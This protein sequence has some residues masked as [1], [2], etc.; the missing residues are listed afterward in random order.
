M[1]SPLQIDGYTID[2][3]IG[4]GA[5]ATVYLAEQT[6]L[7]RQVA[8][9]V[10]SPSLANNETFAKRFIQEGKTIARLEQNNIVNIFDIGTSESC[11]YIA[12]E[13]L[14]GGT[15]KDR[16]QHEMYLNEALRIIRQIAQ[17]LSYAHQHHFVHRDIKPLN[18]MYRADGTVVLTDFGIAKE[19]AAA[20]T[21]LTATGAAIGTPTYM[22]PEQAKGEELDGRSDLYCLGVVFYELL[23]GV[24][25]YMASDPFALALQHINAPIPK[26]PERLSF[27]QGMLNKMMAKSPARRY[28]SAEELIAAIDHT[29]G[30]YDTDK[31]RV[32][33]NEAGSE[34]QTRVWYKTLLTDWRARLARQRLPRLLRILARRKRAAMFASATTLVAM[35]AAMLIYLNHLD[36][37]E[38][39]Q[40]QTLQR[41][42]Q[43]GQRQLSRAQVFFPQG[44]N[45]FDTYLQIRQLDPDN[46]E[47]RE[48]IATLLD[49]IHTLA[50]RTYENADWNRTL[51]LID[52]G[53]RL[54]SEH[55][56][57][58]SLQRNAREAQEQ[59]HQQKL[60]RE[61]EATIVSQL[62]RA[63]QQLQ[64]G[65]L[66]QP[67]DDNA[68]A[69]LRGI[70]RLSPEDPR[71][72]A[73]LR[74]VADAY[75]AQARQALEQGQWEQAE[76]LMEQGLSVVDSFPELIELG[77]QLADQRQQQ[78]IETL[79]EEADSLVA[80][81]QWV[82][83][84]DANALQRYRAVLALDADNADAQRGLSG[85]R[86]QLA[87]AA[88]SARNGGEFTTALNLV[89]QGLQV[90]A[91]DSTLLALQQQISVDQEIDQLLAKAD[92]QLEQQRRYQPPGDNAAESFKAVLKLRPDEDRALNG[93]GLI[94]DQ[95][96][97]EASALLD[98][99][100]EA[101]SRALLEAG[102]G[103]VADRP[104][105]LAL[106][107]QL[108]ARIKARQRQ[109]WEI[110]R[111]LAEAKVMVREQQFSTPSG[112]NA[113]ERY[114]AVLA[115]NPK[116][117]DALQ[118]LRALPGHI[119]AL[120]DEAGKRGELQLRINLL[121][122]G[123]VI[124]PAEADL[125]QA[126]EQAEQQQRLEQL[127]ARAETQIE[128]RHLSE[129]A[130]DNAVTSLREALKLRPQHPQ[131]LAALQRIGT[132]YADLAEQQLA[133]ERE[134]ES[135]A[136]LQKGLALSPNE[137]RLLAVKQQLEQRRQQ[138]AEEHRQ[139]QQIEQ[140]LSQAEQQ[141]EQQR[142]SQPAEGNA[143]ASYRAIL[144]LAPDHP[145]ATAGLAALPELIQQQARQRLQDGASDAGLALVAQGLQL[146]PDDQPLQQLRQQLLQQQ[147]ITRLL[148]QAE[149]LLDGP[150]SQRLADDSQVAEAVAIYRQVLALQADQPQ[151]LR[152]LQ[153]LAEAY[154]SA[155]RRQLQ[156]DD[157]LASQQRVNAG[158]ALQPDHP[159][160]L[161]LQRTL[162]E[163]QQ[164]RQA[165]TLRR[166]QVETLL[167]QAQAE[168]QRGQLDSS[169]AFIERG[170]QLDPQQ[171]QLLDLQREVARQQR[172]LSLLE[173]AEQQIIDKQLTLP[174]RSNAV[175]TLQQVL[176]LEPQHP[177]ALAGMKWVADSYAELARQRL[178]NDEPEQSL[179]LIEKGLS[180]VTEHPP[181]LELRQQIEQRRQASEAL[182]QR[183]RQIDQLLSRAQNQ[184]GTGKVTTPAQDSAQHSY[185]QVLQL[186][187]INRQALS[188]LAAL[189]D[190]LHALAVASLRDGELQAGIERAEEGL[191]LEP[192]NP[193]LLAVKQ[194]LQQQ[195]RIEALL[196]Q[197]QQ[198]F[199]AGHLQQPADANAVSS[200]QQVLALSPAHPGALAGLER[201]ADQWAERA[202]ELLEQDQQ[203]ASQ[204]LLAQSLALV[205]EHPPSLAVSR[206]WQQRRQQQERELLR[207]AQL[208]AQLDDARTQLQAGDLDASV[209]L[210]RQGLRDDPQQPQWLQLQQQW[211]RQRQ[212]RS[213]LQAAEQQIERQQ[214]TLPVN[215]NALA[216]L[217]Q[218]LALAPDHPQALAALERVADS[219]VEMA[220]TRIEDGDDVQAQ[221]LIER[222]LSVRPGHPP[223]LRLSDEIEARK[224][225][226]ATRQRL[227][228]RLLLLAVEQRSQ[229]RY[230]KPRGDNAHESYR[231]ILQFDPDNQQAKQAIRQLSDQ[232]FG[233]ASR[234]RDRGAIAES[235]L[236]TREGLS[237]SPD[238]GALLR[239]QQQLSEF[240]LPTDNSAGDRLPTAAAEDG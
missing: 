32:L 144:Q 163:R 167:S 73:G 239:L 51:A 78:Q 137:P 236:L 159:D 13:Y 31:V 105:L 141:L 133:E 87:A 84:D 152:A 205:P 219:Y 15:L 204:Q 64:A 115:L 126:L 109:R 223:L 95:L 41:L 79:L 195:Q 191:R 145:V 23:T 221:Q 203:S 235:R 127:L 66:Q 58:L 29:F 238:D 46:A 91:E 120:A 158:L 118:A 147:Q 35:L 7:S 114:Q 240:S 192:Q 234:A 47:A 77:Q 182:Q 216:S 60:Q 89:E 190:A 56:R 111:L 161:A 206:K 86:Q 140:L 138:R 153:S 40:Q 69:T 112:A 171:P 101:G 10:M 162:Q 143:A 52:N 57:L 200:Y 11:C 102:L 12:M 26:L 85:L 20:T 43:E 173:Q 9:K 6:S 186:D 157:D 231:T 135:L 201:V 222:G 38:Q 154:A 1:S 49:R 18:V 185:R 123:L 209:A 44:D 33:L 8:L 146:Q 28:Q 226:L 83:P 21:G 168:Q 36:S 61:R 82:Q 42:L 172:I 179:A 208:Q 124:A 160:L 74:Q 130:G 92:S 136:L 142:F 70:Q 122:Q 166:E 27:L 164:Q 110:A 212:I 107:Q 62:A 196:Q 233:L 151:A 3:E 197:A 81:Q 183:R 169:Q 17:A 184:L 198:Q 214:L 48:P 150:E 227:I 71:P 194:Q 155:A 207:Q 104:S 129:P 189:P 215:N 106:Q 131:A 202:A 210:I 67:A 121:Q 76:T 93:L 25:P 217:Q 108:E 148:Q 94:A 165:E 187:P 75:A 125:Q 178:D 24:R 16:M 224:A 228:N 88:E 53:L 230:T 103:L 54:D 63:D 139:Q 19:I 68:V 156:Q 34:D 132:L 128:Q 180:V 175:A 229:G 4:T 225:A 5:M 14:S 170:L 117:P 119:M 177:Q 30:L 218:V 149:A 55:P 39:Q 22:S 90:D 50:L 45:A 237:I 96:G 232:L 181:L 72:A 100:D 176:E 220:L 99:G 59:A 213:L 134:D 113:H 193:R 188:G 80:K 97:N 174:A 2:R 199:E 98:Q 37:L 211:D 116:D 65:K